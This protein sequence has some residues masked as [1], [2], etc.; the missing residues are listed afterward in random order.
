MPCA[1]FKSSDKIHKRLILPFLCMDVKNLSLTVTENMGNTGEK[2][3][4]SKGERASRRLEKITVRTF[5]FC[6]ARQ[7]LDNQDSAVTILAKSRAGQPRVR[8]LSEEGIFLFSKRFRHV[9]GTICN[10]SLLAKRP[11]RAVHHATHLQVVWR[12]RLSGTAPPF[13]NMMSWDEEGYHHPFD[14]IFCM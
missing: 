14:D 1:T 5:V 7:T 4:G 13:P 11:W 2:T 10:V 9:L 3:I 8:F 12:L 6:T